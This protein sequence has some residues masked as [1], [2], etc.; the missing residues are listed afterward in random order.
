[1]DYIETS[2]KTGQG[3]HEVFGR[4]AKRLLETKKQRL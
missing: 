2:A 4:I 1:M 3:V